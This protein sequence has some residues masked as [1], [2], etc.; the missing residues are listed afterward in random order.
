MG[1]QYH[2][3][4]L[5]DVRDSNTVETWDR[6]AEVVCSSQMNTGQEPFIPN[7]FMHFLDLRCTHTVSQRVNPRRHRVKTVCYVTVVHNMACKQPQ[8][9]LKVQFCLLVQMRQN[10]NA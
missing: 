1:A 3:R 4:E 2:I 10:N 9:M 7:S 8:A 5:F 6:S